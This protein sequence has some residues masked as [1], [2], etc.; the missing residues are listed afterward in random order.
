[1]RIELA[2]ELMIVHTDDGQRTLAYPTNGNNW[3]LT[4][5]GEKPT[6]PTNPTDPPPDPGDGTWQ[7]PFQ[8]SRYV[9]KIPEAQ[10]G[11]RIHPITGKRKMHNGLDFGGG[12]ISGL[13]VPAASAGTVV[14]SQYNGGEGNAVHIQHANGFLTKYFHMRATGVVAKG[15]TVTKG[16][17]L[18]NVGTTGA[19]TGA[20]LH[21]ETWANG[22][23]Q[24]PRE[25]MK[26]RGV[27]ES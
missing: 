18:G 20:H 22:S 24:N 4:L 6:D 9:L 2:G 25:F 21:W 12:G 26:A 8:Y 23:T 19:S 5:P 3:T 11:E 14:L 27:P 16:Q 7:W 1:M 15:S 10:Y 17:T 13:P